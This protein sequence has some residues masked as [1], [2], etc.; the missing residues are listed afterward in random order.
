MNQ[1]RGSSDHMEHCLYHAPERSRHGGAA[2]RVVVH[3][4][5]S[6]SDNRSWRPRKRSSARV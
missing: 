1:S 5:L 6:D 4:G 3:G 2:L